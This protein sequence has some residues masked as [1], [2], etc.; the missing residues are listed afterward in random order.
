MSAPAAPGLDWLLANLT[1]TVDH[2]R[3]AVIFSADGLVM[4]TSPGM[5]REDGEHLAALAA[6]VQSLA[7]GAGQ[8]FQGGNVRQTIIEMDAALLF[9][10][11]AGTSTCLAVLA[12]SEADAGQVAYEMTVLVKRLGQH[13][14]T[15]LR[16]S[17]PETGAG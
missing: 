2:V 4:G 5:G 6:G 7:R 10:T 9:I 17:A 11:A 8:R 13:L 1:S 15:S 12:D 16:T 14:G 3:Q